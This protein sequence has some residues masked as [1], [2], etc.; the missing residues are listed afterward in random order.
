MPEACDE[1]IEQYVSTN[2]STTGVNKGDPR[3]GNLLKHC[4]SARQTCQNPEAAQKPRRTATVSEQRSVRQR[5][6]TN[7]LNETISIDL[8]NFVG[9]SI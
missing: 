4:M 8:T 1:A 9:D 7:E 6:Q 2:V 5:M 3:H